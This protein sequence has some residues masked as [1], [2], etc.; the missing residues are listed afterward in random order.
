M[1]RLLVINISSYSP[2]IN[3]ATYLPATR[4]IWHVAVL[5]ASTRV[6]YAQDCDF[7]L[8]HLHST[9]PLE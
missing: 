4:D 2:K 9:P 3:T 7:C 1:S 6:R 8:P 5:T